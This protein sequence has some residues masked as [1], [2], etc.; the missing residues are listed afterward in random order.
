MR[1]EIIGVGN[2]SKYQ[3]FFEASRE[4]LQRELAAL[5]VTLGSSRLVPGRTAEVFAQ[6][7]EVSQRGDL[8][9][10]LT[11]P[12]PAAAAAVTEAVCQ[13]LRLEPRIDPALVRQL[14]RRASQEAAPYTQAEVEAFA[15]APGGCRRILNPSGMVQGYALSA[16]KQLMLVLP[17]TP[18][19]L[20]GCFTST[21]RQMLAGVG[22]GSS[23]Q[24]TLRAVE[25][26]ET[27]IRS[28]LEPYFRSQNPRV[29]LQ[30]QG[31]ECEIHITA[32]GA[33]AQARCD[34][35]AQEIGERLGALLTS[36]Q[37]EPLNQQVDRLLQKHGLTAATAES[38]TGG[39]LASLLKG[40]GQT[41]KVLLGG[42]TVPTDSQKVERLGVPE[43]LLK[44]AGGVSRRVAA[45]MA[46]LVRKKAGASLGL[47]V[48][49]G[50]DPS[51]PKAG[52]IYAAV[53][54]GRQVW[55]KKLILPPDC[56]AE[57]IRSAAC[58]Q[59]LN[60]LRLYLQHYPA[61]LP[62]GV[63]LSHAAPGVQSPVDRLLAAVSGL[64]PRGGS[65]NDPNGE[66]EAK[67]M[68]LIQKIRYKKLTKQDSLR[69]GI[70]GLSVAV[71]VGCIIYIGS[72]FGESHKNKGLVQNQR[73]AYSNSDIRP[74]DVDGYPSGYL[75]KFAALY[76]QNPDVA[77][78][79]KIDGTE[80]LD[81]V[82]VQTDDNLYYERRDF[83]GASNQH[84]VAFVDYRVFQREP[85][86]N[87]IIYSHN[88]NDGQ[89]FGELLKYKSIDFY[90]THPLVSYDSVYY[91]G[92]YKIFAVVVCKKDDPDFLYHNF[93]DKESDEEMAEYVN[94][95]RERSI[96]NTKVDVRT[97]DLLLTMS[98]CDYSFKAENGDHIARFVVFARKV[99]DGESLD[100]D[101]AGATINTNPVMPAEWY[102]HLKKQQEAELKRQQEEAEKQINA[103]WLTEEEQKNLS[104]EEQKALA[105]Q[106]EA[107]A[108]KYLTSNELFDLE[109]DLEA[110]LHLIEERTLEFRLFLSEEE[111]SELSPSKRVSTAR[112]RRAAAEALGITEE[113][114]LKAGKWSKVQ[115]LM[116]AKGAN[117]TGVTLNRTDLTLAISKSETLV[118]TVLPENA[119]N[120]A[121]TWTTS[122]GD[123]ATVDANGKV[124]GMKEGTAVITVTTAE[125]G[126]TAT[127]NVTVTK[128]AV[129]A[130]GISMP[131][132]LEVKAGETAAIHATLEPA[133]STDTI[134]WS[135]S[136]EGIATVS[137]GTVRGIAAGEAVI[138]AKAGNVSATCKVTVK[139]GTVA[140]TGISLNPSSLSLKVGDN[141]TVSANLT[142]EG[143]SGTIEWSSSDSSVATVSGGTVT[144]VKVGSA[145]ITAKV[146][147]TNLTATCSVTVNAAS[148]P[149]T[150][151]TGV[152]GNLTLKAGAS[153]SLS[154]TVEPTNST[155]TI[156]WSSSDS[157][158][159]TV[160]GGT[161]KGIKAGTA[162]ITAQAG[163]I[164]VTCE[165]TVTAAE[166]EN[167][168]PVDP[169]G[170]TN[171]DNPDNPNPV[172]PNP[173]DPNPVDPN[174]VDPNPVDPTTPETPTPETPAE[175]TDPNEQPSA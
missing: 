129:A 152:P 133:D 88:M 124:T 144:A 10:V 42:M 15:A 172:D 5:G 54:D 159:A 95:I 56:P 91:E 69:L 100:V 13:G 81:M 112:E 68:N 157:S 111:M 83:T 39:H 73:D 107:D 142:P 174:P 29:A 7:L 137:G 72:V 128:A 64:L 113:E 131:G 71:F 134:T 53:T 20:M 16:K 77:G 45:A 80:H 3:S 6:L 14:A 82:V 110:M 24:R 26:G 97:D 119:F 170:P 126:F 51:G 33:D 115:E 84:G 139:P 125:G 8:V 46:A 62:G 2:Q 74:E 11:T 98:T 94:K 163:T 117:V 165:V 67:D 164:K 146:A 162:T 96:L 156:T 120:K 65:S 121:V 86:T 78:W 169:V 32:A 41:D 40:G 55:A 141:G 171:P 150:G 85:S 31:G 166:E 154:A 103:K 153:E 123:V 122:N 30:S 58:V 34:E 12:E 149:A 116:A 148:T 135:S 37:G 17:A 106:R 59:V 108:K 35:M 105:Q 92:M 4:Y 70:L 21:V 93:I 47:A 140:P 167:P 44:E 147:G 136:N 50:V 60:M 23:A 161:V 143:A 9:V 79:I 175:T 19:E 57:A 101:T 66:K 38:G 76:A 130:T 75:P 145:T 138:T 61:Q 18:S 109:D 132:S 127:C 22:G 158:V 52:Q 48:T 104:L 151:I 89:M 43:K 1:A 27:S 63:P 28:Q 36:T 87:T 102:A 49:C 155:D 99:R 168:N 114:L 118:A 160:S 173:V 90:R 25:L